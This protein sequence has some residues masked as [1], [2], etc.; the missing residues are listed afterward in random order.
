MSRKHPIIS[1][2]GS[3]GAGT[4]SVKKT[5]EQIFRR[6]NVNAAFIE[7]DAFHRY[8][9]VDM[10]N[11]M[12]EEAERGNRHFSHFS[13][14][15]NLFEELEQTF[16]SYAETG[17]GRTR[18]Y[19]HDDEEAALHGVPPGNF[20]QWQ[21]LPSNSDLLFYEGLHGAVIT[22]KVNVAQHA[23]LKIGVVPVIN[24]EWIQKLHRDRAARGYSTEA[25]T[26]TILRRMP[27]YVHYIVPQ[28]AETDINF[29]R[30]PTVDTS[31][32]FIARWIPTADESMVVIRFK[33]PRGIDFAY[34]LSMIQG[35]FMSRANSIVIHGAKLDLA[36]QLILTPLIMQLI[37][38]KRSMK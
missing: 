1:I 24:L 38:R 34:L 36:M 3:S 2:T 35:S 5:F 20:T 19:V 18:H 28:F 15:T 23:D 9:R 31:N 37:D 22:E 7:G 25:V 17:T 14:E 10:R 6:E 11:K 13:P 30:V 33:N 26:D 21:D 27:D 12:A 29:Q 16:R 4:T 8:N 32:P